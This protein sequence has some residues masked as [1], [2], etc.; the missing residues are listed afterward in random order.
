MPYGKYQTPHV[1]AVALNIISPHLLF[2][3]PR[4]I[5]S[6]PLKNCDTHSGS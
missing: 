2:N 3:Q 4:P 5:Q 1:N 6:A